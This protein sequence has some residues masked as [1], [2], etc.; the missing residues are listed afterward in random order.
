MNWTLTDRDVEL[1]A[2][3]DFYSKETTTPM[4]PA[5]VNDKLRKWKDFNKPQSVNS[6]IKYLHDSR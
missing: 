3:Y 1:S 5:E 6:I 2:V 4:T